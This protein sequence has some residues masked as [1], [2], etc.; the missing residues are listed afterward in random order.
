M[1]ADA[2][3]GPPR[4]DAGGPCERIPDSVRGA[5]RDLEGA[6]IVPQGG[7]L[8][9]R[10][11][12]A[13]GPRGDF[14]LQRLSD[15]FAP[16][17][18]DNIR[19]ITRRL[20]DRG[21]PT[22]E[23]VET[24]TGGLFLD[25]AQG[26]RWR[27]LTRLE[28]V[29][30]EICSDAESARSATR[31][32]A[33]FHRALWDFD[34]P[35]APLG[36][37]FHDTARHFADL[38]A[39]I[40][41]HPDHPRAGEVRALAAEVFSEAERLPALPPLP[42]RVIHGD[43]KFTNVLFAADEGAGARRA[44]ALIDFDTLARMPLWIELGDAWRSWCNRAGEDSEEPDFEESIFEASLG[45]Y[46]EAMGGRLEPAERETL[47]GGL[48][49]VALE[50]AARFAADALEGTHWQQDEARFGRDGAHNVLRARGQLALAR[51]TRG[52]AR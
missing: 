50:L 16:G 14:I 27:L 24:D 44:L 29:T 41:D 5:W 3:N 47:A 15:V 9:H 30:R 49:R 51:R 19:A 37:V 33:E 12:R 22:F 25:T 21:F 20:A 11:L 45:A 10:T 42:A 32:A 17:I 34:R 18:H 23:L 52:F 28:G 39:A 1:V 6:R 36:F 2:G 13:E 35:L 31:L 4:D 48:P 26:G 43:L 38:H 40:E 7:G 46:L 8:L